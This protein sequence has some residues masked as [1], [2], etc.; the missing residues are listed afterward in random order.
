VV[1][2]T[3]WIDCIFYRLGTALAA[4]MNTASA[5]SAGHKELRILPAA[6][7]SRRKNP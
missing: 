7:N 2:T 4:L 5:L 3:W 1:I 6:E